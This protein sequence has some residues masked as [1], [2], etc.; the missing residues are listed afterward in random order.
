MI[1][2][3]QI[4]HKISQQPKRAA[5][6]KQLV[7]EFGLHGAA[8]NQLANQLRSLVSQGSLVHAPEDR[9][10]IP[11]K[12]KPAPPG[13]GKNQAS[14][15]LTMH[16]D[17][18]GF[19]IPDDP[20]LAERIDG[21]IFIPPP[22]I[23]AAMHGDRVIVDLAAATRDGGRM[24]GRIVKVAGR[25]HSTVVGTFHHGPKYN[26]VRPIDEKISQDVIIP[27]GFEKPH[28]KDT[29]AYTK[30]HEDRHRVIGREAKRTQFADLE[31]VDV[32]VEITDWPSP[33]QNPRGRVVEVLGYED[34]S[35]V[36]VEIMIRK[37][38]IPHVFP[39]GVLE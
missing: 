36:D 31:N 34:D 19:V 2:E 7:R 32:D 28:T 10:A 6:L 11:Q 18:F 25:A 22:A 9:F 37:R 35:G 5:T 29:K 12:A 3:Q 13:L 14:G 8:R 39:A 15:R 20:S 27:P 38:H 26:Y 23:G 1:S 17:G 24:E 30:E 21:D 4:M 33:T 16:R